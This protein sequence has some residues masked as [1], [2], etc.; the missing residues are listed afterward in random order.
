MDLNQSLHSNGFD[1][2]V[3]CLQY[4]DSEMTIWKSI[5][6]VNLYSLCHDVTIHFPFPPTK[7]IVQSFDL[8][9]QQ[10]IFLTTCNQWRNS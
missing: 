3:L 8:D 2:L 10:S 6:L 5:N 9:L 7:E 1:M 4:Y